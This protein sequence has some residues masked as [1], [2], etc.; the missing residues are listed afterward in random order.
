MGYGYTERR[1]DTSIRGKGGHGY[2]D[3]EVGYVSTEENGGH[4]YT[5]GI[6]V[7]GYTV[8]NREI[9]IM[10]ERVTWIH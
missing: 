6:W 3:G 4:V 1:G 7:H 2:I 9:S 8:G 5:E 10:I